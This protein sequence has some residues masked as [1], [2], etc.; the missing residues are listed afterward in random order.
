MAAAQSLS[1]KAVRCTECKRC[2][3]QWNK[4]YSICHS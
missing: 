4:T 1:Y 2:H 3:T